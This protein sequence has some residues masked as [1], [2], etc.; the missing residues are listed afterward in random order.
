MSDKEEAEWEHEE[1]ETA[2]KERAK[3]KCTFKQFLKGKNIIQ[4]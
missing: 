2:W 1:R 4:S 3:T